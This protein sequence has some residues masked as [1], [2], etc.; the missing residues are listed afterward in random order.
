MTLLYVYYCDRLFMGICKSAC[1][2]AKIMTVC[3]SQ[4]SVDNTIRGGGGGG[5]GLMYIFSM[6]GGTL[7]LCIMLVC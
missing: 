7:V 6:K 1:R 4:H 5:G 2:T 3:G